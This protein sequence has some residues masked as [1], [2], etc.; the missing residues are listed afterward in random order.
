MNASRVCGCSSRYFLPTQPTINPSCFPLPLPLPLL[1]VAPAPFFLLLMHRLAFF[2]S[3]ILLALVSFAFS[4]TPFPYFLPSFHPSI[5]PLPFSL[6]LSSLAAQAP[7]PPQKYHRLRDR[8]HRQ[9]WKD[10]P[11]LCRRQRFG[12]WLYGAAAKGGGPLQNGP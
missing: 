10:G 1:S 7:T 4:Q 11:S 2:Y 8:C 12:E 6:C 9:R 5:L 3:C